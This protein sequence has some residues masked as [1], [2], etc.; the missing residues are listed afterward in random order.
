MRL[1]SFWSRTSIVPDRAEILLDWLDGTPLRI[2]REGMDVDDFVHIA[3][4]YHPVFSG[5]RPE[6][7]R[8]WNGNTVIV[9]SY[10]RQGTEDNHVPAKT[11]FG[12][13][14]G[15]GVKKLAHVRTLVECH[16]FLRNDGLVEV[17]IGA[18]KV[19]LSQLEAV[20]RYGAIR[21]P[22]ST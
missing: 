1:C 10:I 13:R 8:M 3:E 9:S 20:R 22:R 15:Y 7:F 4:P 6:Y 14:A 16:N 18:G 5:L 2:L 21:R 12:S 19:I 11:L 17:P